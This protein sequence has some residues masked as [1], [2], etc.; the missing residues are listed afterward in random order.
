[1]MRSVICLSIC[2]TFFCTTL[3]AQSPA[4]QHYHKAVK[5]I[6]TQSWNLALEALELC[7]KQDSKYI[8]AWIS[9]GVVHMQLKE[10]DTALDMFGKAL[11]LQ[12]GNAI[13]LYN[14]ALLRSLQGDFSGSMKD[15]NMALDKSPDY[16]PAYYNRA[17]L[18]LHFQDTLKALIDIALCLKY[19]ADFLQAYLLKAA[20]HAHTGHLDLAKEAYTRALTT[21]SVSVHARFNRAHLLYKQGAYSDALP[22]LQ[23]L[24]NRFPDNTLISIHL[25]GVLYMLGQKPQACDA[26]KASDADLN[27]AALFNRYCK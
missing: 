26:W 2:L 27:A 15:I 20:L 21:D 4:D 13:A 22:D 8:Q 24:H 5:A 7:L 10:Y 6:Q 11:G 18:H 14:R 25:G 16:A 17:M 3:S 19:D 12:P 9:K 1:M 23:Y